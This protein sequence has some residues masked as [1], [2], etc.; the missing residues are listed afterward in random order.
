M[1]RSSEAALFQSPFDAEKRETHTKQREKNEHKKATK[2]CVMNT[3]LVAITITIEERLRDS[4]IKFNMAIFPPK[5]KYVHSAP[6][7][8]SLRIER[9]ECGVFEKVTLHPQARSSS[10]D[11]I[12]YNL[13]Q[14]PTV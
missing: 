7:K 5:F 2:N 8:I 3:I 6:N 14:H 1:I 11:K 9:S 10:N 4:A 13:I 12:Y